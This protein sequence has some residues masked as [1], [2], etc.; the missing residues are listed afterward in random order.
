MYSNLFKSSDATIFSFPLPYTFNVTNSTHLIND[1]ADIPYDHNLRLA[2][3]DISN[4]YTNIPTHE[5]LS[6]IDTA[7]NNNLVEESLKRDI[8][9]LS[10]TIINQNYLQYEDMTY[11]QHEGLAMGAPTASIFSEFY[12][13]Y[14]ENSRIYD[15][16]R[17]HNIAGYFCYVDDILIV[18]NESTTNIE[19]LLHCFNS[20]T[21]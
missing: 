6:I 7:C 9:N 1:L 15:L 2:S 13:Q 12:L 16:L 4:M 18:Y 20:L 3:F 21:P 19:D 10:K 11:R 8:I 5:L 17:S 14:Q